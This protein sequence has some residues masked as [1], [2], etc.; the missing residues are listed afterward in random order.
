MASFPTP[1]HVED[2]SGLCRA[3]G[4][5]PT[6]GPPPTPGRPLPLLQYDPI[7][8]DFDVALIL[9]DSQVVPNAQGVFQMM[10]L[11]AAG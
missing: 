7:T 2:G 11:P 10:S 4:A 1:R 5:V 9:L 3:A 6:R 8:N